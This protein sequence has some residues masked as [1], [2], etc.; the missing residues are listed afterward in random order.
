LEVFG[1]TKLFQV[2]TFGVRAPVALGTGLIQNRIDCRLVLFS[3]SSKW[4]VIG[5]RKRG[6]RNGRED[7]GAA[8]CEMGE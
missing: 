2:K 8:T 7:G 5:K 6:Q 4:I 3:P 1:G